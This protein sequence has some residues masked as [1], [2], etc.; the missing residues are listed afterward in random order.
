MLLLLYENCSPLIPEVNC[1]SIM[2][3]C[4]VG[5]SKE[6]KRETLSLR[7][8]FPVCDARRRVSDEG[9]RIR[10]QWRRGSHQKPEETLFLLDLLPRDKPAETPEKQLVWWFLKCI[11]TFCMRLFFNYASL[12]TVTKLILWMKK[13]MSVIKQ[14]ELEQTVPWEI[15]SKALQRFSFENFTEN[16]SN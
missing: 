14:T 12:V 13:V 6:L 16:E 4:P 3:T 11:P 7:W 9:W 10:S 2:T 1:S 15:Y 5:L 8:P